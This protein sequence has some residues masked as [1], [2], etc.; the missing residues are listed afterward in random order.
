MVTRRYFFRLTMYYTEEDEGHKY[1]IQFLKIGSD[2]KGK[3]T[4]RKHQQN[5]KGG[6]IY[7]PEG[8]TIF[9]IPGSTTSYFTGTYHVHPK[10]SYSVPTVCTAE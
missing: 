4:S 1:E 9:Q 2:K 6:E 7:P 3:V 10:L 8:A 5:I